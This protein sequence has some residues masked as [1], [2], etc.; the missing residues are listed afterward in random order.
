MRGIDGAGVVAVDDLVELGMLRDEMGGGALRDVVRVG[1]GGGG[2]GDG[3]R[4]GCTG[5]GSMSEAGISE[6]SP[7]LPSNNG[8]SAEG[9]G[10]DSIRILFRRGE[11][12]RNGGAPRSGETESTALGGA[13]GV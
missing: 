6:T 12:A 9:G 5:G 7:G 1:L 13:E 2:G 8:D 11:F 3:E 4:V 10:D